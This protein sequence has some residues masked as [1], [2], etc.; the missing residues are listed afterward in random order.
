MAHPPT[1][2]AHGEGSDIA[3]WALNGLARLKERGRFDMSVTQAGHIIAKL[4]KER[5]GNGATVQVARTPEPAPGH[6]VRR[7]AGRWSHAR[8]GESPTPRVRARRP[9]RR[10]P[11]PRRAAPE[12]ASKKVS[13][14]PVSKVATLLAPRDSSGLFSGHPHPHG[15]PTT[16]RIT[17]FS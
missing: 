13:P 12:R 15:P 16:G 8:S 2:T 3:N 6:T 14:P 9:N 11:V 4:L 17:K 10:G 5:K 1:A 7:E